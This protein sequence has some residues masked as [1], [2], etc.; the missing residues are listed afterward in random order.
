MEQASAAEHAVTGE[1]GIGGMRRPRSHPCW[2]QRQSSI[3]RPGRSRSEPEASPPR[4]PSWG[5]RHPLVRR[6]A[7]SRPRAAAGGARTH[8]RAEAAAAEVRPHGRGRI[9]LPGGALSINGNG[10]GGG[11]MGAAGSGTTAGGPNG[12]AAGVAGGLGGGGGGGTSGTV[13][14]QQ[15]A[16]SAA[17]A[18]APTELATVRSAGSVPAAA[19]LPS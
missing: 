2:K 1:D 18:A 13:L 12:G 19:A 14:S 6:S 16:E 4:R 7:P 9:G 11:G 8:R 15:P 17:A 3:R 10:G 5:S